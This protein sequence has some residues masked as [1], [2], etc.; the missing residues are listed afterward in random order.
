M[1]KSTPNS[2]DNNID[3]TTIPDEIYS[4]DFLGDCVEGNITEYL[5]AFNAMDRVSPQYQKRAINCL[6]YVSND[7]FT[8]HYT[9]QTRVALNLRQGDRVFDLGCGRGVDLQAIAEVVTTNGMVYG[10]DNSSAMVSEANSLHQNTEN[11]TIHLADGER[12]PFDDNYFDGGRG[13]RVLQHVES[14]ESVLR[15]M[16]RVI[17]SGG[18]IVLLDPDWQSLSIVPTGSLVALS[19]ISEQVVEASRRTIRNPNVVR[20]LPNLCQSIDL[21]LSSSTPFVRTMHSFSDA[22]KFYSL[23]KCAR[24]LVNSGKLNKNQCQQW[25]QACEEASN[26]EAF[27]LTL[28]LVMIKI[29]VA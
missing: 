28:T 26:K 5:S 3:H 20:E 18:K 8:K 29:K 13:I 15:E 2:E 16:Q 10:L 22:N 19:S 6:R 4:P 23:S 25:I 17:K 14:P 11:I 9:E 24:F 12:L 7:P 21:E 27:L 1:N